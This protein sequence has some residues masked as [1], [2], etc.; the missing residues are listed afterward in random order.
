MTSPFTRAPSTRV[1]PAP[2]TGLSAVFTN[3]RFGGCE[4]IE[5]LERQDEAKSKKKA[6]FKLNR[7]AMVLWPSI[8]DLYFNL[9]GFPVGE[10]LTLNANG[11][12]KRLLELRIS[13]VTG[14]WTML[15]AAASGPDLASLISYVADA[16]RERAIEF[17]ED[18]VERESKR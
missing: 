13:P 16:S 18:V 10:L 9:K 14:E 1:P 17:L 2:L 5:V 8:H 15:G 7:A 6:E 12:P 11:K 4:L 3:G